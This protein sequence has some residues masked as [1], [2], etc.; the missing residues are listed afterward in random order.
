MSLRLKPR[1]TV[2]LGSLKHAYQ[3]AKYQK[4]LSLSQCLV[5]KLRNSQ[6]CLSCANVFDLSHR[7]RKEPARARVIYILIRKQ[8][9]FHSHNSITAWW[10]L[11]FEVSI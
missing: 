1:I 10:I 5:R 4:I 6:Y 2:N 8:V 7:V 9:S 3:Q 11:K